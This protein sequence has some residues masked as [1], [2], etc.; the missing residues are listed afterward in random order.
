MRALEATGARVRP[1][2]RTAFRAGDRAVADLVHAVDL[3]ASARLGARAVP[4]SAAGGAYSA[5]ERLPP[6]LRDAP[7]ALAACCALI[8]EVGSSG[9]PPAPG[10]LLLT[11]ASPE[12]HVAV[13]APTARALR[14]FPALPGG[15]AAPTSLYGLF[16]A[17]A[18][19]L[20]A[21]ALARWVRQ[22]L[23]Q[24]PAIRDRQRLI[25]ALME[26]TVSRDRLGATQLRACGDVERVVLRLARREAGL[27]DFLPLYR[28]VVAVQETAEAL[29]QAG[30]AV[31]GTFAEPLKKTAGEL[32]GLQA[33]IEHC[34]DVR[35]AARAGRFLLRPSV[36]PP[37][38]QLATRLAA[39]EREM[40]AVVDAVASELGVDREKK[41]RVEKS[42]IH[43][44]CLRITKRSQAVRACVRGNARELGW[45]GCRV[46]AHTR[47]RTRTLVVAFPPNLPNALLWWPCLPYPNLS[48]LPLATSAGPPRQAGLSHAGRAVRRG[49]VRERRLP[50]RAH[51]CSSLGGRVQ[52]AAGRRGSQSDR[53]RGHLRSRPEGGC[54]SGRRAVGRACSR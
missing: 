11:A 7:A 6:D 37:L 14:L 53:S 44:T 41:L 13:D 32:S 49:A 36:H 52:G 12:G 9:Q 21:R 18:G 20:T 51:T 24:L 25:G 31:R 3:A 40:E 16:S 46:L 50:A 42:P 34:I 45:G 23:A 27:P 54:S 2:P 26:D 22:P 28:F 10:S 19:P 47:T 8:R 15:A 33:L 4:E 38:E 29:A 17:G 48:P 35:R 1:L 39:A 30:P 5:A 43:G